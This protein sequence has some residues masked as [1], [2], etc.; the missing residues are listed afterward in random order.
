[1]DAQSAIRR[2][3]FAEAQHSSTEAM[4]EIARHRSELAKATETE[5]KPEAEISD[6]LTERA[7]DERRVDKTA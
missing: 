7:R 6:E 1:M 3:A 4:V 2:L 5:Q